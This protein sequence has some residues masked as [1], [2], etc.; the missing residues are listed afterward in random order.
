[1]DMIA[2]TRVLL[3]IMS[4]DKTDVLRLPKKHASKIRVEPT[5]D[6][7]AALVREQSVRDAIAAGLVAVIVFSIL[8]AMLSE[9]IDRVL[10]WLTVVLGLGLGFVVRRAGHGL[11]WRFPLLAA[12]LAVVGALVGNI[13]VAATATAAEFD[14]GTLTI[15]RAVTSMTWPEFFGEKMTPADWVYML[16]AAIIAAVYAKR[17]LSRREYLALRKWQETNDRED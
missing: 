4:D 14:T 1:M 13:F 8:W 10:P 9:L 7:G 16:F 15:L 3:P 17:R 11:D 6:D 5:A 2:R 12:V